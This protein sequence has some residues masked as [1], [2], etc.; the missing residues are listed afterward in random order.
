[1][2]RAPA[3]RACCRRMPWGCALS[4]RA[5]AGCLPVPP[6]RAAAA[7]ALTPAPAR[8]AK[9]DPEEEGAEE[10]EDALA[11]VEPGEEPCF[12][13]PRHLRVG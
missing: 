5:R 1:L 7:Q 8:Q 13:L 3:V 9:R 6:C 10:L 2:L 4:C 11:A 12:Q